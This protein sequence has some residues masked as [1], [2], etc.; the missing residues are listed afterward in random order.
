MKYGSN[1]LKFVCN[2]S[3][4]RQ[5]SLTFDEEKTLNNLKKKVKENDS[6]I[7]KA[8]KGNATVINKKSDYVTKMEDLFSDKTKFE[9]LVD[10]DPNIIQNLEKD[11]N[12]RLL[13][14]TDELDKERKLIDENGIEF[15][16]IKK[17]G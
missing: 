16:P 10:P 7:N 8:D 9:L 13:D 3:E 6:V 14:I 1:V 17:S 12:D 2:S 11:F 5:N 4:I 15:F